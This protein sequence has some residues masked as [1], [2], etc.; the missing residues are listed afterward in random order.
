MN[1]GVDFEI[2]RVVN[3]KILRNGSIL[4]FHNDA[5]DTPKALPSIIKQLKEKGYEFVPLSKLIHRKDFI[6]DGEGRQ[7]LK[8]APE[9]TP[10]NTQ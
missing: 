3:H 5:R 7:K 9:N 10:A 6:I 8:Q 4:L 2:N 1:K